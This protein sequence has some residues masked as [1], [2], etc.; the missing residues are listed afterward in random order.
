MIACHVPPSMEFSRQECWSGL[1]LPSPGDLPNPGI[2]PGSP[3]L[4]ADSLPSE[5]LGKASWE[6]WVPH[7]V[8]SGLP[9]VK[10]GS[11]VKNPPANAGE[12][13]SILGFLLQG[14]S[15]T[16]ESNL[17]LLHCRQILYCLGQWGK[18][19]RLFVIHSPHLENAVK[20]APISLVCV[21]D[22]LT[23]L[24]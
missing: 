12:E 24:K 8:F 9:V 20:T 11:V 5:P 3:V 4:Q 17:G 6:D 1:P 23:C 13:S 22:E 19:V 21:Q 18:L 14:I 7:K 16:Q 15:L 10:N 2:K